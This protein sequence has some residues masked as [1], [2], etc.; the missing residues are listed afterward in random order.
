MHI[1]DA[2]VRVHGGFASL[3][4]AAVLALAGTLVHW[5]L[6]PIHWA[7]VAMFGLE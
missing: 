2:S 4:V 1:G 5:T 3:A 7:L 6:G